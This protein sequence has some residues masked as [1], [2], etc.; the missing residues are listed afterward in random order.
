[1]CD[2][3]FFVA[4]LKRCSLF[5]IRTF[6]DTHGRLLAFILFLQ[7]KHY[8]IERSDPHA[9]FFLK[10]LKF[11]ALPSILPLLNFLPVPLPQRVG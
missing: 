7:T 1:M 11:S 4:A 9:F 2:S 6:F 3:P 5:P 10:F 8:E